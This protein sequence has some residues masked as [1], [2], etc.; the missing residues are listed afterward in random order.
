M[1]TLAISNFTYLP[2][3]NYNTR[4]PVNSE[5]IV[6]EIK[7]GDALGHSLKNTTGKLVPPPSLK[8][9]KVI[10]VNIESAMCV[11]MVIR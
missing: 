9:K 11:V 6:L 1:L 3:P 8:G 7:D 10:N 2:D 5:K 4:V